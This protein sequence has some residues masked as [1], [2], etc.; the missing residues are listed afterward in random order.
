MKSALAEMTK[1]CLRYLGNHLTELLNPQT[2]SYK[3]STTAAVLFGIVMLFS[4]ENHSLFWIAL[5]C[6]GFFSVA[7]VKQ[8]G[9][10][11][12]LVKRG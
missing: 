5:L 4:G 9:G 8:C 1:N 3:T 11:G 12:N 10:L 2:P 6:C 7:A